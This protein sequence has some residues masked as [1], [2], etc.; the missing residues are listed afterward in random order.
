MTEEEL[1]LRQQIKEEMKPWMKEE[2]AKRLQMAKETLEQQ[3]KETIEFLQKSGQGGEGE[4]ATETQ[5]SLGYARTEL[6]REIEFEAF[7]R[8]EEE[9]KKRLKEMKG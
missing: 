6:W 2:Y 3:E 9:F 7:H 4:I 5:R 8:V 1:K